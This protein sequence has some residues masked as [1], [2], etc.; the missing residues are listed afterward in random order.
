V[1]PL[2]YGSDTAYTSPTGIHPTTP[3][4]PAAVNQVVEGRS[5]RG[6]LQQKP[7]L[8]LKRSVDPS[9]SPPLLGRLAEPGQ[10]IELEVIGRLGR[11]AEP[12]PGRSQVAFR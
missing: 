8:R 7:G 2:F 3:T 12:R 4:P 9:S 5:C 10:R 11:D 6:R 1:N